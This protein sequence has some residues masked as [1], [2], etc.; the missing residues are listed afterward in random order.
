ASFFDAELAQSAGA[1]AAGGTGFGLLAL[2][3]EVVAGADALAA[4]LR[5]EQHLQGA[6]LTITGEGRYDEQTAFGKVAASLHELSS[7]AGVL[8][9]LVAGAIEGDTQQWDAA[10]SL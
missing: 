2:G 8:T 10:L 5:F 3:A 1:G 7:T 9:A 6:S 4:H